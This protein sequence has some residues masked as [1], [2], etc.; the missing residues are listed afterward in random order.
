MTTGFSK[1]GLGEEEASAAEVEVRVAV[2]LPRNPCGMYLLVVLVDASTVA[3]VR[4]L[5]E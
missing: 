3:E 4:M 2:E 5:E 1:L